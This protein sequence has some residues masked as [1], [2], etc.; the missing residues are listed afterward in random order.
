LI[1]KVSYAGFVLYAGYRIRVLTYNERIMQ[2]KKCGHALKLE[3]KFC[4]HCGEPTHTPLSNPPSTAET[5]RCGCGEINPAGRKFCKACGKSATEQATAPIA[6][7]QADVPAARWTCECQAQ[8][9]LDKKFCL[10][11]GKPRDAVV[12]NSVGN[13]A[14]VISEPVV[15]EPEIASPSSHMVEP[16]IEPI[17]V[18]K[19]S[20]DLAVEASA[21][22]VSAVVSSTL[23]ETETVSAPASPRP[24]RPESQGPVST[25]PVK[26]SSSNGKWIALLAALLLLIGG[27]G[28]WFFGASEKPAATASAPALAASAVATASPLPTISPAPS[29]TPVSDA[30]PAPTEVSTTAVA[31]ETPMVTALSA[32][33]KPTRMP[34]PT[35]TPKPSITPQAAKVTAE[36]RME[37]AVVVEKPSDLCGNLSELATAQCR[38]C[39][40]KTGLTKSVCEA[41]VKTQHCLKTMNAGPECKKSEQQLL[42]E[43]RRR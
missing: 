43:Q 3:H 12:A 24:E 36:P 26:K 31:T 39:Q 18:A 25:P 34:K 16:S 29:P 11:C 19:P 5:W 20:E 32:T 8:N 35:R 27:A 41:A 9:P 17:A 6:A 21:I 2:C 13:N 42:E 22:Q 33:P 7:V 30:S 40:G 28:W 4:L 1:C 15:P 23:P 10:S 38:S 37:P 14:P